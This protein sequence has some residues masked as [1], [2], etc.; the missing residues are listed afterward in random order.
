MIELLL[1]G[2][3][4]SSRHLQLL[5][6]LAAHTAMSPVPDNS[7]NV[8]LRPAKP[9]PA[10]PTHLG[11]S[12]DIRTARS[13]SRAGAPPEQLS[14]CRVSKELGPAGRSDRSRRTSRQEDATGPEAGTESS[15]VELGN[16]MEVKFAGKDKT[17]GIWTMRVEEVPEP[18]QRPVVV[19][20]VVETTRIEGDIGAWAEGMGYEFISHHVLSGHHL[21]HGNLLI[22]IHRV[23]LLPMPTVLASLPNDACLQLAE[24]PL[25]DPAG[26]YTLEVSVRTMDKAK[27]EL[28]QAATAELEAFRAEMKGVVALSVPDRLAMD[29][30]VR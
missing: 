28:I 21:V 13:P 10:K 5:N 17:S 24:L 14:I 8:L 1:Y 23:S 20:T 18:G 16:S 27:P 26:T 11:G 25:L 29:T 7:H 12:Q 6:I 19:R 15:A 3:I 30:R 2:T 22:R 4:P 9:P